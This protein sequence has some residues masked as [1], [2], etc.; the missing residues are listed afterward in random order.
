MYPALHADPQLVPL[1]VACAS[2]SAG[3]GQGLQ[4]LPQV[5]VLALNAHVLPQA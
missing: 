4:L 3:V 1:Q 5:A 2:A